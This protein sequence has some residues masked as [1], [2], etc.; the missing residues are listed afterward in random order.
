MR[1]P[2]SVQVSM[3]RARVHRRAR[4]E[5]PACG[6]AAHRLAKPAEQTVVAKV[7]PCEVQHSAHSTPAR[8]SD[9]VRARF[10]PGALGC[11]RDGSVDTQL[12]IHCTAPHL[13][14]PNPYTRRIRTCAVSLAC[15]LFHP[16]LCL[17]HAPCTWSLITNPPHAQ[18]D[19]C[20]ACPLMRA[21][22]T[23][24][25]PPRSCRPSACPHILGAVVR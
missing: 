17:R 21:F 19:A 9:S 14:A 20:F 15:R 8:A 24:S 4:E 16:K 5:R 25:H 13:H 10:V 18:P 2:A 23:P 3:T 11:A 1:A 6:R 12:E 7:L 22:M